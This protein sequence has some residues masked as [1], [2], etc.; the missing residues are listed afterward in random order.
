MTTITSVTFLAQEIQSETLCNQSQYC[1]HQAKSLQGRGKIGLGFAG[2]ISDFTKVTT[3]SIK[4]I[5]FSWVHFGLPSTYLFSR[6][7]SDLLQIRHYLLV[8]ELFGLV[9]GTVELP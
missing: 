7:S 3:L 2:V 5:R 4:L 8:S 6:S 1:M 9:N